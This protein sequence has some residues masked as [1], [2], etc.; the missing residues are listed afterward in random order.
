MADISQINLPDGSSFNIKDATARSDKMDK[1]NPTGTGEL[2]INRK[3]NTTVGNKSSTLGYNCTAS[4]SYSHAEGQATTAS[5]NY[6][7]HAEGAGSSA[8][9]NYSHA[10]GQYTTAQGSSSHVEGLSSQTGANADGAHAEGNSCIANGAASHAEGYITKSP[11]DYSHSEGRNTEAK[12]TASHA[13]GYGTTA[14]HKSQ[15]VFGEYNILDNSEAAATEKGNYVEVVGNGTG[16]SARSNARTLDWS[17]NETLAGGLTASG[18][19]VV[20][21]S[22]GNTKVSLN[23]STGDISCTSVNGVTPTEVAANPS[24]TGS[25]DLTKIQIGN[26]IYNIPQGGGSGGH[27][28]V[29][30]EGTG[31]TQRT[32]LQFNGAYLEDDSINDTT[33]VNVV[34]EM[35]MATFEQLS[36]AEKKGFIYVNDA[37]GSGTYHK[38]ST[39]EQIIGEWIDGKTIFER[40]VELTNITIS[41]SSG[42]SYDISGWSVDTIIK[43]PEGF[44]TLSNDTDL[45]TLPF[46]ILGSY[47]STITATKSAVQFTRTGGD[48]TCNRVVFTIQYTKSST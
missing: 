41:A 26:N 13:E 21:D 37:A 46:G 14:N 22:E 28:I 32:D 42:Y 27:T 5:G 45:R 23:S 9:G 47:A 30:D 19:V 4:G 10:E 39:I 20:K 16:T 2:S 31:L 24:D 7:S 48:M 1:A 43:N 36:A 29:D 33:K 8:I 25:A 34:R 40:T 3:A 44:I 35:N 11:G 6:G 15:H 38:Y 12:G 17:G 18:N